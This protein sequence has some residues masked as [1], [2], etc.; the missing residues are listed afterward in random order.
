MLLESKNRLP[1]EK[2]YEHINT[3]NNLDFYK[4][5]SEETFEIKDNKL[6][7]TIINWVLN[8]EIL[9]KT[10]KYTLV[11]V[12]WYHDDIT[13]YKL[14]INFKKKEEK[15][16]EI[17]ISYIWYSKEWKLDCDTIYNP[18]DDKIYLSSSLTYTDLL[19]YNDKKII[20]K[21]F[22]WLERVIYNTLD[23]LSQ[24]F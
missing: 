9:E 16:W 19:D 1:Q 14:P 6:N 11:K 7:I 12:Y 18:E 3:I 17:I 22:Y 5:K 10:N 15:N 23:K 21:Y 13:I 4:N 2:L 20:R 8:Y 24:L